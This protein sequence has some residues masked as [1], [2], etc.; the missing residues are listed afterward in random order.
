MHTSQDNLNGANTQPFLPDEDTLAT[1]EEAT[2]ATATVAAATAAPAPTPAAPGTG[3][4]GAALPGAVNVAVSASTGHDS[5]DS[6]SANVVQQQPTSG[7]YPGAMD[8]AAAPSIGYGVID[9][10]NLNGAQQLPNTL[11]EAAATRDF[12]GELPQ[13]NKSG[14]A[15]PGAAATRDELGELPQ[16]HNSRP[17]L[18]GAMGAAASPSHRKTRSMAAAPTHAGQHR[19]RR[20]NPHHRRRSSIGEFL[21]VIGEDA[22]YEAKALKSVWTHELEEGD[23]G[24]RYFLDMNITRSLSI[25]PE[26]ILE[27]ADEAVNRRERRGN[28]TNPLLECQNATPQ[29][30]PHTPTASLGSYLAL[31][32]A[33]LAVSSN[34]TAVSLLHDVHPAMRLFWRMTAVSCVLS[35]FAIKTMVKQYREEQQF[36]PKLTLSQW[37]LFGAAAVSFFLHALLLFTALTLTSIGNAVIMANSQALLLVLGKALT[38]HHVVFLEGM[39]VLIACKSCE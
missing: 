10:N 27:F 4:E 22:K 14:T 26:D 36:F 29:P 21:E 3:Y 15:L 24:Q 34:G 35:S 11:P 33:V 38:G 19:R 6:N 25:L 23:L 9:S 12:L 32:A 39:G 18:P 7:V 1:M 37:L 31:G 30:I 5:I 8:E 13:F 16:F 2:T 17:G 28:L 20:G